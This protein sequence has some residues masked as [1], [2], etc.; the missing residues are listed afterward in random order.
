MDIRQS[1]MALP[2]KEPSAT[3]YQLLGTLVDSGRRFASMADMK[4]GEMGGETPVG[5][6]MAIMERGTKV[7]SAIHKRLHYSQKQEFKLLADVIAK[8]SVMYPY[9]VQNVGPDIMQSDFDGRIDVIPVSDPNI[10]SMSQRIALAQT[11]LQLVQSNPELHGGQQGLYQAYRKMYEALGMN[12]IDAILPPPQQP[13]PMNPAKENQEAMRGQRLQAFPDQNHQA[14][15]EAHIA[16]LSTPAAQ[17]NANIVMTLQGHIQEHIGMIAEMQASE[18]VMAQIPPEQQSMLQVNPL[19]MQQIQKQIQ[20]VA[21]E[22]VGQLTE[23]YAQAVAPADSTDPLVAIRQQELSLRGAEIQEKA[24]Q[25]EEK[26]EFEREKER[27]DILLSQQRL[28]LQEEANE[29]KVRV[30]EDRIQTQRD[31]AAANIRSKQ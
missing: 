3:L 1:I 26:Q 13:Q 31:I 16:F 24:R 10:F 11:Q 9:M 15:I 18:Q 6:T 22:I 5:T 17:V 20:D 21:A 27:N 14:H 28:D 30:A 23:Q 25:F 12:N 29:E 7:M 19:L 4:I 8:N 2:F